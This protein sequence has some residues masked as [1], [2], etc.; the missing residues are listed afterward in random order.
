MVENI[1]NI[2]CSLNNQ[3]PAS[4]LQ[5]R[6]RKQNLYHS[7][8]PRSPLTPPKTPLSDRT[9]VIKLD[10]SMYTSP[11]VNADSAPE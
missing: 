4:F 7:E 9:P 6:L 10:D 8:M 5:R 3:T 11:L 1:L 2:K